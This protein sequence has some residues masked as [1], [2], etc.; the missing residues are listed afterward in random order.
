MRRSNRRILLVAAA[1]GLA[2][3]AL[4]PTAAAAPPASPPASPAAQIG[5]WRA[6]SP[7]GTSCGRGDPYKFYLSESSSPEAGLLIYLNGGGVCLKAG[8]APAGAS[9]PAAEL[10]CMSFSNF[11][12]G[13]IND[14]SINLAGLAIPYVNRMRADNPFKEWHYAVLP[15]CTGDVHAGSMAEPF[16]Y[17]PAPDA[18]FEVTQR[19]HLNVLAVL[20]DLRARFPASEMP[21]VLTGASAGGF[22][23]IYNF[24]YVVERWPR[25]A[26]IPDAGIGP[27]HPDSLLVREG[28]AVADRWQARDLLPSYCPTEDCLTDT[29]RL[30]AAHARR[31]D[32]VTAPWLPFGLLQGQQDGTLAEFLEIERCSYQTA[33]RSGLAAVDGTPNLG[34]WVPATADHVFSFRADAAAADGTRWFEWFGRVAAAT[35]PADMPADVIDP[36]LRCNDLWLPNLFADA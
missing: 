23:A 34:A 16:D 11:V 12:D 21:V 1:A 25:T 10:Y 20:D 26:L 2:L 18:E 31:H 32:G 15:Y 33:L 4:A 8:P 5:G 17:D 19:G 27:G 13:A 9:G 22:G 7:P 24:P 28:P 14:L 6:I 29:L 36:W 30:M 35:R 3:A